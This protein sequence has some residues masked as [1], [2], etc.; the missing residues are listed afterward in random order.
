MRDIAALCPLLST[1]V[2]SRT[3]PLG[4]TFIDISAERVKNQIVPVEV[5]SWELAVRD[6]VRWTE[7]WSARGWTCPSGH[8]VRE[9]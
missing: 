8:S 5:E 3:Q 6:R 9:S 2:D 7:D 1:S 4:S